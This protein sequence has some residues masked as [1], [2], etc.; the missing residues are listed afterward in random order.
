MPSRREPIDGVLV[1]DKPVGPT[2]HDVVA[3]VRRV[4][5]E[6]RVGH[7]GTL[8]PLASGVLPLVIGRA[9]RLARFLS[10]MSKRYEADIRLG[11]TTD[12]DDAQGRPV[13]GHEPSE[14][15]TRDA[16]EAA[17]QGFRG[18]FLQRP[19]VYSAKHIEG[20]RSYAIAR[21]RSDASQPARGFDAPPPAP[22]TVHQ[23]QIEALEGWTL[24]LGLECSPGFYV[25]SLAR[26]LGDVLGTGGHLSALRRT[27]CGEFTLSQALPLADVEPGLDRALAALV[28][29]AEL[30][31]HVM[32]TV[33]TEEGV[34]RAR[35]GRD[36]GPREWRCPVP[37]PRDGA[38]VRLLDS[39][40]DLIGLAQTTTAP[41]ALHPAVV[42][43]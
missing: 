11:I 18:S 14:P 43:K 2:S 1:V 20:R 36:L 26:D 24:R 6:R 3:R 31:P 33:L 38:W 40:G 39:Q 23:L 5:D 29:L 10:A 15:P 19:P 16:V 22:V 30:L 25:R 42:L 8:D 41:G 21:G 28:P 12:T 35:H 13:G 34:E 32:P 27:V 9:T 17:L 4:L 7:T 37:L